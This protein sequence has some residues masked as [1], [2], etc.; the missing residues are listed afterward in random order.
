M[1]DEDRST[2]SHSRKPSST[3]GSLS[4][5]PTGSSIAFNSRR[6]EQS[7]AVQRYSNFLPTT[8]VVALPTSAPT[9]VKGSMHPPKLFLTTV[10]TPAQLQSHCSALP[11]GSSLSRHTYVGSV[12]QQRQQHRRHMGVSHGRNSQPRY[13]MCD[14]GYEA[15]VQAG[16]GAGGLPRPSADGGPDLQQSRAK[17]EHSR[18]RKSN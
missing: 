18:V 15:A 4:A 12:V 5:L 11:P 9:S 7:C 14:C 17:E 2:A 16:Q 13:K 6:S 1:A 8:I 3:R 10:P